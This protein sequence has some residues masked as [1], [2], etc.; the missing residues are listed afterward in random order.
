MKN[1]NLMK[2]STNF[3][4]AIRLL[5]FAPLLV[6]MTFVSVRCTMCHSVYYILQLSLEYPDGQPVMLDSSKVFWTSQNRY[7]EQNPFW[8]ESQ[9]LWGSYIIVCDNMQRELKDRSEL[10]RFTGYLNGEVVVERNVLVGADR[11]HVKFL[12]EEPLTHVVHG[13]PDAVRQSRFCDLITRE[14]IINHISLVPSYMAFVRTLD[15][16][17]PYEDRLQMIVDWLVSHDCIISARIDCI[18]CASLISS[19]DNSRIA[20]SFIENEQTVNMIIFVPDSSTMHH[21]PHFSLAE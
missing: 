13:V 7:L 18:L 1:N 15:T 8:W 20:F 6:A 2:N 17:L 10:M 5:I 12:E 4:K 11:C 21:A 3:A 19:S 16:N 9:R 14:Q